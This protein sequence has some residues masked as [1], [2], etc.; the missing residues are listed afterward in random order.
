MSSDTLT[1]ETT[2]IILSALCGL[3]GVYFVLFLL[4]L[5]ATYQHNGVSSRRLRIV[6]IVQFINLSTHFIVRSLQFAR[7]RRLDSSENELLKWGI[8]LLVIG[9]VTTTFSG[10]LSDGL[11]AWRFYV[12][13]ER[14]PW[15]KWIPA[16]LVIL[17][18]CL[19]WS[20]D[21]QH[22]A[23]YQHYDF[24]EN[25]LY[26]KTL[27]ITAAWGFFMLSLNTGFTGLIVWKIMRVTPDTN[28]TSTTSS[29][30]N[31]VKAL[32]EGA[33]VTWVGILLYEICSL[34][35]Q[36]GITDHMDV[37]YVMASIL[38]AFLGISQCLITFRLGF[39]REMG[40]SSA[41]SGDNRVFKPDAT[42]FSFHAGPPPSRTAP[43]TMIPDL[44]SQT[45]APSTQ[46]SLEEKERVGTPYSGPS[47]EV[48]VIGHKWLG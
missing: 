39:S 45:T 42:S 33:A 19:C 47:S 13:Y 4:S 7:A 24:Y 34:A 11:L 44:T 38:P 30:Q 46:D 12:I 16:T 32:I 10:L 41:N 9:N 25:V 27:K 43:S 28:S 23:I 8:P 6:T 22:L 35:P 1:L 20:A 2:A 14:K 36:G 40:N 21:A 48:I 29:Y 17:N 5:W 3:W 18:A 31:A 15:A 26:D 37:G